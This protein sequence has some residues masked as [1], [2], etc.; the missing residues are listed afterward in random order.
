MQ[1][2]AQ[3]DRSQ[4]MNMIDKDLGNIKME[5]DASTLAAVTVTAAAK[6]F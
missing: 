5:A 2:G 6:P 1:G 4:M 3:Q